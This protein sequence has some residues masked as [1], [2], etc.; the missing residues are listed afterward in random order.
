MLRPTCEQLA[1]IG[2][3]HRRLRVL[4]GPG[5]GKTATLVES[6]AQRVH[7]RG[8][9]PGQI[10]VLTFSRRAAS[11]LT[12]RIVAR[13][14]VTTREPV[15]RTLHSYAYSLVRAQALRAGEPL[16]RLIGAAESDQMIRE[17]LAGHACRGGG[18]WPETLHQALG[19]TG[20]A[21]ELRDFLARTTEQGMGPGELIDWGRRRHRPEWVAVGQFAKEYSKVVDLRTGTTRQGQALDQAELMGVALGLLHSDEVLAGE[22]AKIRRI[23]VDEYQD[24]DP[25]QVRLIEKL[26]AGSDEL[27]VVGDPDQSIYAFRGSEPAAMRDIQVDATVSLT[28]GRRM[29]PLLVEATRR[30]AAQLPGPKEHRDLQLGDGEP[31]S[32]LGSVEVR[33]FPSAAAE[34]SFIADSLRRAHLLQGV[35][36]S[37]MAVLVRSPVA[38][39]S[40]LQRSFTVM[41]VPLAHQAN[42]RS[43]LAD[44]TVLALMTVLSVGTN[45]AELTGERAEALLMSP[46]GGLDALALRRLR[47]VLKAARPGEGGSIDL[48][49]AVL[50]G[51]P[52]PDGI[53]SDL[54]R[55]LI[56]ISTLLRTVAERAEESAA[57]GVLWDIWQQCGIEGPL[58]ALSAR[59]GRAGQRADA[60][61]DAVVALFQTAAQRA[62]LLPGAGIKDFVESVVGREIVEDVAANRESSVEAVQILSAHS[63]KG[64]EWDVVAVAGVEEGHWPGPGGRYSLLGTQDLL[65]FAAGVSASDSRNQQN[66]AEERRLFYV[67]ATRARQ[68]LIATAVSDASRQPS[69]FLI[70]LAGTEALPTGAPVLP[71]G[72]SR[73]G[74]NIAE[75]V[76]ELRTVVSDPTEPQTQRR[77]AAGHLATLALERSRGAAPEFWWGLPELSSRTDLV[78]PAEMVKIS[79][80]VVEAL[81]RCAL[82]AVLERQGGR[83]ETGESQLEGIVVHAMAHGIALELPFDQL[84]V[85]LD[86]YLAATTHLAPWQLARLRRIAL[87]MT[88]AAQQWYTDNHPPWTVVGSEIP[89]Q[90]TVPPV[91]PSDDLSEHA[92]RRPVQLSGRADWISR[93]AQGRPVI[94]DFKTGSTVPSKVEAEKN[95]QLASYQV[96]IGSALLPAARSADIGFGN[97]GYGAGGSSSG[98]LSADAFPTAEPPVDDFTEE[99][100]PEDDM[101]ESKFRTAELQPEVT[102]TGGAAL[103]YLRKG[104]PAVRSQAPLTAQQR[105]TWIGQI[106]KAADH[107]TSAAQIATENKYCDFCSVRSVCPVQDEGRQATR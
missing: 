39:V 37:K 44:A 43:M 88:S 33:V 102:A 60:T 74:L 18:P 69:R 58:T 55:P 85:E 94:I 6:V 97:T 83:G 42:S 16:P 27:I 49:A 103:V 59:G 11:E 70:E 31:G 54:S 23:F 1:I 45:P 35:P 3:R 21:E 63:S 65:D 106:R 4:A 61:L 25:A 53:A 86:S 12:S 89:V 32:N 90:A 77:A 87:S 13:L 73:R 68:Q 28:I 56:G 48:L 75:L 96:A 98:G 95:P 40:A 80:S 15:V 17:L 71:N 30:L 101:P 107:L 66:L 51:A 105:A 62:E 20:F 84:V 5:T 92:A 46:L 14:G 79:P 93:D 24:V 78:P 72:G 34:A 29:R 50:A 7:E 10:L 8:V 100:P 104:V 9:D 64:L 36:W 82:G 91:P 67:A 22:Q 99:E 26:A 19:L 57:E 52:A 81:N 38:S 47:R 76:A 2:N 41:G